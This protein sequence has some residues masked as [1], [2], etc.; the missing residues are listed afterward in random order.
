MVRSPALRTVAALV[1]VLA[2][3]AMPA[4]SATAAKPVTVTTPPP[5]DPQVQRQG[6][7]TID[8]AI[9][10]TLP[11]VGSGT[12]VGYSDDY[13]AVCPYDG[14]T[15]PDVVYSL[16]MDQVEVVNVDLC[17]SSYDTKVY[18]YDE[19]MN[20]VACND[21]FYFPGDPCGDY[22]SKLETLPLDGPA[23]YFIV[24]DG[25]GGDAGEYV[26]EVGLDLW[27][28]VGCPPGSQQENEPPLDDGDLDAINGGCDS[29]GDLGIAPLQTVTDLA[30][31][32]DTGWYVD[33]DGEVRRDTDWLVYAVPPG[34]PITIEGDADQAALLQ[35]M[36]PQDCGEVGVLQSVEIGAL[37]PGSLVIEGPPS[38]VVWLRVQPQA[39]APPPM[40]AFWFDYLLLADVPVAVEARTFSAVRALY[41]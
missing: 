12:T 11:Y 18:V 2:F 14:S 3:V 41:R 5:P 40:G 24:I 23:V 20:L 28:T 27:E 30:F 21:D 34:S 1:L 33:P 4:A 26:L 37:Q 16:A 35:H 31:C 25:Y 10:I 29:L 8:D 22:V 32:G 36:A 19:A 6:G 13:D 39:I 17:G 15:S 38:G 7:D 9:P